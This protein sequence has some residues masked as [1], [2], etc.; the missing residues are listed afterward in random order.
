MHPHTLQALTCSSWSVLSTGRH[1]AWLLTGLTST[2]V[3]HFRPPFDSVPRDMTACL[4]LSRDCDSDNSFQQECKKQTHPIAKRT[5]F[6]VQH[7][8][9]PRLTCLVRYTLRSQV[10][11]A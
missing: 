11:Q 6:A 9:L 2:W 1:A 4:R 3:A 8:P 10:H 7:C 5:M